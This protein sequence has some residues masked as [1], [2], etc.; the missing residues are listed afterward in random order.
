VA[1]QV[2]GRGAREPDRRA[3]D[4]RITGTGSPLLRRERSIHPRG[5]VMAQ[6]VVCCDGTWQDLVDDSNACRLARA[7]VPKSDGQQAR[8]VPGVGTSGNRLTDLR[9][10]LTAAGLDGSI[11]DAYGWLAEHFRAGDEI[12]LFGFSRGA[13]TARSVAGMIGLVGLVAGADLEESARNSAVHRAYRRYRDLRE[14]PENGSWAEGITLAYAPGD[15]VFPI[16]FIGVWDTVGALGIPAYVGVPDL[17]H[18]RER[19]QFL[20]VELNPRVRHARHAVSLDEMR[21]PFR[22]TLWDFDPEQDV[23]Q[24]WFP[25]DH[26]DVGGGHR[27]RQLSD[28]TLQWMV[29]EATRVAGL[30]F[31]LTRIEGFA[32]SPEGRAH[33]M[34]TGL[35]GAAVEIAFQPRPRAVPRIDPDV[36]TIDVAD[37]TYQRRQRTGYRTTTTLAAV[38]D[39][40]T[41]TVYADRAWT[42]TG[43]YLPPGSYRCTAT[44]RWSSFGNETDPGGDPG[45]WLHLSG[46]RLSLLAGRIEGLVRAAL[47]N[48]EAE[49][50]GTRRDD[51]APWM[52]LMGL[53]AN[54]QTVPVTGA[55]PGKPTIKVLPDERF[56]IGEERE[57]TTARP[58]YLYA[59]PNDAFGFYG[60]NSGA[61]TLTVTR[62]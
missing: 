43:L 48:P 19:Y 59:Y 49:V 4:T 6:L 24:A 22:P 39:R 34:P 53:V 56:P 33:G 32:P 1:Q 61:V 57:I 28:V 44:G 23:V 42:D 30:T 51:E 55:T 31:D 54:E 20:D 25:G 58:G 8:Y 45:S 12:S 47:N 60:N 21:G 52:C 17:L 37:A 40:V 5:A 38:G 2:G 14:H 13:Y 41:T 3:V 36:P 29:D 50:A 16:E 35:T 18:S 15:P 62:I 10:G 26:C 46:E 7:F 11:L 9:A 27:E